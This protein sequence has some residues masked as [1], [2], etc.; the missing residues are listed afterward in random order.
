MRFWNK[1]LFL[2][3][4]FQDFEEVNLFLLIFRKQFS[5]S[6][7]FSR[8]LETRP[9]KLIPRNFQGHQ[10]HQSHQGHQGHQV[11]QGQPVWIHLAGEGHLRKPHTCPFTQKHRGF[12]Q[13]LDVW[14][15]NTYVHL[16]QEEPKTTWYLASGK[17]AVSCNRICVMANMFF[18]SPWA[19]GFCSSPLHWT[20]L[21]FT[22]ANTLTNT[23]YET[24]R[25]VY[26]PLLIWL[27]IGRRESCICQSCY[28]QKTKLLQIPDEKLNRWDSLSLNS[29]DECKMWMMNVILAPTSAMGHHQGWHSEPSE[30]KLLEQCTAVEQVLGREVWRQWWHGCQ[31]HVWLSWGDPAAETVVEEGS[32]LWDIFKLA[33]WNGVQPA[34]H[35]GWWAWCFLRRRLRWTMWLKLAGEGKKELWDGLGGIF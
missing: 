13:P 22:L 11:Y 10:S 31:C 34:P 21:W 15:R 18:S 8:F 6:S 4:N 28:P 27:F 17:V 16:I 35:P 26:S 5:F 12:L 9:S 25:L 30:G 7:Q 1:I 33:P 23:E 2:F 14:L 20:V 32:T 29:L 19:L 3:L 24:I